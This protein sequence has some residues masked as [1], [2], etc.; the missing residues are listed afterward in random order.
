MT[1]TKKTSAKV[2]V[3]AMAVIL[4]LGTLFI[5]MAD[6]VEAAQKIGFE[7]MK[8]AKSQARPGNWQITVKLKNT[9]K[10]AAKYKMTITTKQYAALTTTAKKWSNL[11]QLIP[12]K[13]VFIK[14]VKVKALN[15]KGKV[16]RTGTKTIN[17]W[18]TK[19]KIPR[20]FIFGDDLNLT[21]PP[22]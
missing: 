22:K 21:N 9:P 17:A 5:P 6:K 13:N 19:D 20:T 11:K 4:A 1:K 10:A 15:A 7:S 18:V 14:T 16:I 3:I 2:I 12:A 8:V